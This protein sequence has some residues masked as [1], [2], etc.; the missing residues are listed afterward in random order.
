MG[1]LRGERVGLKT[2]AHE[3]IHPMHSAKNKILERKY[4]LK[5]SIKIWG[6]TER[7][8]HSVMNTTAHRGMCE[9]DMY[10]LKYVVL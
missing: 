6:E 3:M 5:S 4:L 9:K 1:A 10:A 7:M 8:R 2:P